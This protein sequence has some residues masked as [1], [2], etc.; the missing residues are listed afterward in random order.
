MDIPS[1]SLLGNMAFNPERDEGGLGDVTLADIADDYNFP[2]EFIYDVLCRW[3]VS[4]P[5]KLDDKLGSLV[6]GEQAF[7]VVE[8][9]TSVDPATVHDFYL[10]DTIEELAWAL[11]VPPA[12]IFAVCGRRRFNLPLG[13]ETHLTNEEYRFL[14]KDL[15]FEEE[16]KAMEDRLHRRDREDAD[17]D[18]AR[19]PD[20]SGMFMSDMFNGDIDEM[21]ADDEEYSGTAPQP[22]AKP[23]FL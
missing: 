9:L 13:A 11:D 7:A 3:G 22:R 21:F 10:D 19:R 1:G 16:L 18:A 12:D 2:V 15:G 5:I 8:A 23:F 17:A 14:L 20:P 6:N 4:P